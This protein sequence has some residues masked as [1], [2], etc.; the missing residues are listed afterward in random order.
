MR[1]GPLLPPTR[2]ARHFAREYMQMTV[3]CSRNTNGNPPGSLGVPPTNSPQTTVFSENKCVCLQIVRIE[4]DGFDM[5][6]IVSVGYLRVM[7][8][9]RAACMLPNICRGVSTQIADDGAGT[10]AMITNSTANQNAIGRHPTTH[11]PR[12][13]SKSVLFSVVTPLCPQPVAH[14]YNC[15]K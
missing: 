13:R 4:R 11:T 15:T 3:M 5:L 1:S 2:S 8:R 12:M 14:C 6:P 10:G 9:N 7:R